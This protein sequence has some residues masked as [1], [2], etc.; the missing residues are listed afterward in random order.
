MLNIVPDHIEPENAL[1]TSQ[2]KNWSYTILKLHQRQLPGLK[3]KLPSKPKTISDILKWLEDNRHSTIRSTQIRKAAQVLLPSILY[4]V[5]GAWLSSIFSLLTVGLYFVPFVLVVVRYVLKFSQQ[6]RQFER[7]TAPEHAKALQEQIIALQK[8][9]LSATK[10]TPP[11][12]SNEEGLLFSY[13]IQKDSY[14]SEYHIIS[15]RSATEVLSEPSIAFLSL[16][17][18]TCFPKA[19]APIVFKATE[20]VF[21]LLYTHEADEPFKANPPNQLELQDILDDLWLIVH[22]QHPSQSVSD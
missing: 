16:I 18:K 11:S 7:I 10:Q 12:F 3:G 6:R 21:H 5:G 9:A 1:N 19:E 15:F 14:S 8:S 17:A 22:H 2:I 4:V 13:M 20:E